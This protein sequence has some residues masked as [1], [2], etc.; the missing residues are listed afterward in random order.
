M[1]ELFARR[2]KN[3]RKLAGMSQ[4]DLVGAMDGIVKKTS[5]AKYERAEMMPD[6]RVVMALSRALGVLPGYFTREFNVSIQKPEFRKKKSLGVKDLESIEQKV[7]TSLELYLELEELAGKTDVFERSLSGK[8]IHNEEDVEDAAEQLLAEWNL[9]LKGFSNVFSVLEEHGI[10]LIEVA[11]DTTFDGFSTYANGVIPVIVYN[12]V[13]TVERKRLTVLHELGHLL[14]NFDEAILTDES[15]VE[16]LCFR[17]GAALMMPRACFYK[18]IGSKRHRLPLEE[19]IILKNRYGISVAA[20]VRR[21]LNLGVIN[22][23]Y[24]LSKQFELK[25]NRLEEGWGHYGIAEEPSR[26]I[27]LLLR[28]LAEQVISPEKASELAGMKSNEFMNKYH[29][30]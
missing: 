18:E 7:M 14:L 6:S 20:I 21:A 1:K 26:F 17:F 27:Q 8:I 13:F 19:L 15:R 25:N 4:D 23:S 29:I 16:K 30:S 22:E 10:R 24:Y 11:T 9:G 12:N 2:L 28:S 5:I 3:A